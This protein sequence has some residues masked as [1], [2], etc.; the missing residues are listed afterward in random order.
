MI[1]GGMLFLKRA[2]RVIVLLVGL[3]LGICEGTKDT[4][5]ENGVVV[6]NAQNNIYNPSKMKNSVAQEYMLILAAIGGVVNRNRPQFFVNGTSKD[7]F[8]YS[9]LSQD[10]NSWLHNKKII[11]RTDDI[12]KV[13]SKYVLV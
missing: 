9:K 11:L 8:W 5:I 13:V 2:L 4:A 10:E 7:Q 6:F 1:T 12:L 3:K